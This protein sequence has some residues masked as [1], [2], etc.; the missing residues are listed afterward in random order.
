MHLNIIIFMKY[1]I[2]NAMWVFKY[3]NWF[4]CS[5]SKDWDLKIC[6]FSRDNKVQCDI[7]HN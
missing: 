5:K 3:E 1:L 4:S 7:T 2:W 6:L